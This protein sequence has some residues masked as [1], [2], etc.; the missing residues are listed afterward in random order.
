MIYQHYSHK[1][2]HHECRSMCESHYRALAGSMTGVIP[3]ET[4]SRES[5]C[6]GSVQVTRQPFRAQTLP[7]SKKTAP[8][9]Q[10]F[11]QRRK[12]V[13]MRVIFH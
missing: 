13:P 7:P 5:H 3:P 11:R 10:C 9:C 6:Y 4:H 2:Y 8:V 1:L 12:Q